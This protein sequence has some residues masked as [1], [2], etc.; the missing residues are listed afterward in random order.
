M[1]LSP[2]NPEMHL[3]LC[4]YALK[5]GKRTYVDKTFA[6]DVK[7]A[8]QLIKMAED[9]K[10][11]MFSSSALR[12]STE[13]KD[14]KQGSIKTLSVRGPG[15]YPVYSIHQ[16]EMI[17]KLMGS[18]P[19]RVM[20]IGTEAAPALVIEYPENK[21]ATMGHFGWEC[22]FTLAMTAVNGDHYLI[23]ECSDFFPNFVHE[24]VNFFETGDI[25]APA[26][27]TVAVIGIRET[28]FKAINKPGYWID[29]T[30]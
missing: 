20:A 19:V 21:F 5:S 8:K 16:I 4:D 30:F 3:S 23:P 9:G 29:C 27:E 14:K 25:K 13:L 26:S 18:D 12:F 28:G 24:L 17:V 10:T 11:P 1:I 2:N 15:E 6:P 7:T 22:P